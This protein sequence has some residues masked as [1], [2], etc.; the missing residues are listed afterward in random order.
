MMEDGSNE[1]SGDKDHGVA[2]I[3]T[4]AEIMRIGLKLIHQDA[5]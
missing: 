1:D 3:L 4:T 5:Q 2:I